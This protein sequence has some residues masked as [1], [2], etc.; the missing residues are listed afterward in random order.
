MCI[1]DRERFRDDLGR[2]VRTY[3]FL[4]QVVAFTD[5]KL[6]RDYLYCK[7][8]AAFVKADGSVAVHPDVELTH[9]KLEQSFEGSVTLDLSLIHISEPTRPY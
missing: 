7:A 1:R 2:F 8:L 5:T 9:L 6:E 3:A 4:S